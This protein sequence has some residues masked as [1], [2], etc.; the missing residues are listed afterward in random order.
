MRKTNSPVLIL[1]PSQ[2][3]PDFISLPP[4]MFGSYAKGPKGSV[5]LRVCSSLLNPMMNLMRGSWCGS[6]EKKVRHMIII[7]NDAERIN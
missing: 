2:V 5:F 3:P 7:G 1:S 4:Y 6:V